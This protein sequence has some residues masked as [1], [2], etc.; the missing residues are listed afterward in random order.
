MTDSSPPKQPEMSDSDSGQG[1]RDELRLGFPPSRRLRSSRDFARI[2]ELKQRAGDRFIL[3]F[4]A[5]NNLGSTR[6]GLSVSKKHGNSI[7]R[8]RI[9]RLIREAYR[10]VQHQ[11]PEGLDLICIPRAHTGAGLIDF[12]ESFIRLG[13]RLKHLLDDTTSEK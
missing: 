10:Q 2:Y 6:I 11:V 1:Q 7:A 3:I 5:R 9:R 13:Q 4:A 8:H 12:Q